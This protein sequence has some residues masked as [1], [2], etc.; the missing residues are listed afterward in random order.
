[1]I[2]RHRFPALKVLV[3][4]GRRYGW[5]GR[6]LEQLLA[7][8]SADFSAVRTRS[9]DPAAMIF[10]S[11]STGPPKGVLYR[12][13]NFLHQ[14]SQIQERYGIEPGDVDL[15]GFPLFGLFNAAM[16]VST[17][18][19]QMNPSRPARVDPRRI[20][21][22]I[23]QW[24][25]TQ[26]FG[27]PAMWNTISRWCERHQ[28]RIP[29]VRR[30]LSAGAPV[31]ARLLRRMLASLPAGAQMHTPYGATEALPVASISADEVLSQTAVRTERGAGICVGRRF[32]GIEWR[33]IQIT[34]GPIGH[35][36][37]AGF[38]PP[39][40]VGELI[41]AGPVVTTEYV[42][43]CEANPLAKIADGARIWHRMGDVGYL[44][45]DDRFWFCGRK[46]HRVRTAWGEMYSVPCEAIFEQHP[47]I[48]RAALVGT[49]PADRQQPAIICQPWPEQT[50]RGAADARRLLDELFELGQCH[51]STHRILRRRLAWRRSLPVDIRHNSK[52]AREQ[53]AVWAARHFPSDEAAASE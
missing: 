14:V 18:V 33:V 29:W 32:S 20:L 11:G 1:V 49:G 6:T 2:L 51:P 24:Q 31:P 4:V 7:T 12:H 50:P 15:P 48:Y 39:G 28:R 9:D 45:A 26:S 13:G 19:P 43:R 27:S 21:K 52:I 47:R 10:T 37:Q 16:G 53:L 34:D 41:V 36:D 38:V 42:T 17:I 3:T 46:S 8:G 44:D 40:E 22:A 35:L 30:V 23:E 5:G 25:V